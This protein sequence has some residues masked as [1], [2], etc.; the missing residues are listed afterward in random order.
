[1]DVVDLC[2][3]HNDFTEAAL[4]AHLSGRQQ[5]SGPSAYRCEEC[6]D[7]IPEERRRAEPGTHHCA[8]CKATLEHLQKRGMR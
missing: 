1:M 7:A 4:E 8:L 5:R 2:S 6:G 3:E